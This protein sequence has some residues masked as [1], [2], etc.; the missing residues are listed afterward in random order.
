MAAPA[1][2]PAAA[3]ILV[4]IEF[5]IYRFAYSAP[6]VI[7]AFAQA[8]ERALA[9]VVSCKAQIHAYAL[10]RRKRISPVGIISA[11]IGGR[12]PAAVPCHLQRE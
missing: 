10:A 9:Q 7:N 3:V 4:I 2:A 5:G 6:F 12:N 8:I 11:V 1:A